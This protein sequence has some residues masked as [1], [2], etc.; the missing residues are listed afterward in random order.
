MTL[1]VV[2]MQLSEEIMVHK[3][4][5]WVDNVPKPVGVRV[6]KRVKVVAGAGFGM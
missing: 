3:C 6:E 4:M 2:M 5:K 1:N